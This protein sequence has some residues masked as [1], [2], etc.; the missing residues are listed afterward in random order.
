MEKPATR[1][2]S[3]TI[4][5][6]V[7]EGFP[8]FQKEGLYRRLSVNPPYTL[9]SGVETLA[10]HTAGGQIRF[11]ATF[12]T[13]RI[14][15]ALLGSN[16]MDHMPA[17]GQCGFDVYLAETGAPRY[18]ATARFDPRADYY[19]SPLVELPATQTLEVV[20]NFPLYQGVREVRLGF[21][22]DA[23]V[24]APTP[25]ALPGR[26][27]VYGTSI[28]QG[29]CATRPGMAYTNILSR[30]LNAEVVNL[31]F[32]GS[33]QCEPEA[34]YAVRDVE[35]IALYIH[36]A[37]ANVGSFEDIASRYPRFLRIF[38]ETHPDTPILIPTKIP[39]A[40]ELFHPEMR[41]NRLRK[42]ELQRSIVEQFCAEG[43]E[44]IYFLDGETLYPGCFEEYAVDGVHA[45]DLGFLKM[46][47]GFEPV[48]RDILKF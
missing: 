12:R 25:R 9:P 2:Y 30:R 42:K 15:A 11:R 14:H 39:Y 43:D 29:G 7:L 46:A 23:A 13:L 34:A 21:D 41:T 40:K 18:Y 17:T 44:N 10:W 33:G 27:V 35:K 6:F 19:E 38:R 1:W 32:S 28:T 36:D 26:I 48:I 22:A 16:N 24:A 4:A 37:E 5:P 20:I 47:E 45:T 3:P 31:G 8:F